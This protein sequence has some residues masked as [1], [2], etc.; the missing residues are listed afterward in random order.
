MVRSVNLG[1]AFTA[2]K[3]AMRT[4]ATAVVAVLALGLAL[5]PHATAQTAP[6]AAVEATQVRVAGSAVRA[7]RVSMSID[8]P[9]DVAAAVATDF[10]HYREFL[11]Q[12]RQSRI[13][14]RHRGQSDVYLQ[15][16]L[17]LNLGVLWGVVRFDVRRA[18]GAM[19]VSG[20]LQ[21]GNVS[22]FD[23]RLEL[24]AEAGGRTHAV[25]QLLAVP[26]LPF[27]PSLVSAQQSRWATRGLAAM[28][29]RAE[30][31]AQAMRAIA[32]GR[33]LDATSA[34]PPAG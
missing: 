31:N 3:R 21:Q 27:P 23:Y 4:S 30:H 34:P 32:G 29:D 28:R 22:R 33:R 25:M 13:V 12:V 5:P 6:V 24:A 9:F 10:M 7:G 20:S 18:P 14:R 15:V 8:A 11:P 26:S 16:P 2:G 1:A 19:V 17:L